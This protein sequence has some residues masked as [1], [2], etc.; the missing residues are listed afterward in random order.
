M[1]LNDLAYFALV[2]DHGGFSAASRVS[3]IPK[4]KLSRRVAALE[5]R[6]GARLLQRT[7]RKLALT[8]AGVSFH[9]HCAAMMVEA[10]AAELAIENLRSEP[11]GTVRMSCPSGLSQFL[12]AELVADFMRIHQRVRVELEST[13][14]VVNLIDERIDVVLRTRAGGLEESALTA[15]PISSGHMILVA[16]PALILRTGTVDSLERLAKV[17]TIGALHRGPEQVWSLLRQEEV[18]RVTVRPRFLCSDFTGQFQAAVGG[19]GAALIPAR[20]AEHGIAQGAL[21]RI[22]PDWGTQ[23]QPIF[24]VF[25]TRRG[26]LPSVRAMVDFLIERIPDALPT[27]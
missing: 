1:D 6:L 22:A 5:Q 18:R 23:P 20:V 11:V 12:I 10:E 8:E 15:R 27:V 17:D 26:M 3:H 25:P 4:S 21:V 24:V 16:S 7:T 2:V 14:R 9:E 13:D 19:V